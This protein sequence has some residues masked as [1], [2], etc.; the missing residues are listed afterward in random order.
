LKRRK[1]EKIIS[2]RNSTIS[3]YALSR[4]FQVLPIAGFC[5]S[6]QIKYFCKWRNSKCI[7][8][9]II[10]YIPSMP[11][12]SW[13][14]KSLVLYKKIK[15]KNITKFKD[16]IESY[17]SDVDKFQGIKG[18]NY[19][20]FKFRNTRNS[21]KLSLEYSHLSLGFNWILRLRAGYKY[22]TTI[23]VRKW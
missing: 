19:D 20:N 1:N 21:F 7:I 16:I 13:S 11:C 12:Y 8:K 9:D 6:L 15:K 23:V 5:T 18:T 10:S 2:K 3:V 22:S 14:K 4:D 17:W